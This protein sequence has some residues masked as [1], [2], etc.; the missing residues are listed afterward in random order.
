MWNCQ[1]FSG[2]PRKPAVEALRSVRSGQGKI[3]C[4]CPVAG[5][6]KITELPRCNFC[7]NTTK[8]LQYG[9]F[10]DTVRNPSNPATA[11]SAASSSW[12]GAVPTGWL[13]DIVELR[14]WYPLQSPVSS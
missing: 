2:T 3:V 12:V 7:G 11:K 8:L 13:T 5:C 10:A 1:T 14:C 4:C 9:T 6:S